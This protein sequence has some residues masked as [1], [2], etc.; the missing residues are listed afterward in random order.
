MSWDLDKEEFYETFTELQYAEGSQRAL[1]WAWSA[2]DW[3]QKELRK[4]EEELV[5]ERT[6]VVAWLRE[7]WGAV[8]LV[9]TD[10]ISAE[11]ER[12]EHRREEKE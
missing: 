5:E 11:I 8:N 6:A 10:I 3:T 7:A 2:L 1:E 4:K 9:S 12:G